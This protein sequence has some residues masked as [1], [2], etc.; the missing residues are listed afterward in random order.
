VKVNNARQMTRRYAITGVPAIVVN[1]KYRT[2]VSMARG[3]QNLI[4]VMNYLVDKERN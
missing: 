3:N 2:G 4:K 1:G